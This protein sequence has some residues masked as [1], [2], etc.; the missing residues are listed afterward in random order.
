MDGSINI[1]N[2][3][4]EM[5]LMLWCTVDGNDETSI[6]HSMQFSSVLRPDHANAAGVFECLQKSL[7]QLGF[8]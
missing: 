7:Q 4:E 8:K 6:L 5:F 2:I 1:G 3:N